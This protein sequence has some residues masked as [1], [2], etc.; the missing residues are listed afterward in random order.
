MRAFWG[1]PDKGDTRSASGM[2]DASAPGM[3][4]PA[5][6]AG[7]GTCAPWATDRFAQ[8]GGAAGSGTGAVEAGGA[9]VPTTPHGEGNKSTNGKETG[10]PRLEIAGWHTWSRTP[11]ADGGDAS[12]LRAPSTANYLA[13]DRTAG[14]AAAR[15]GEGAGE[16]STPPSGIPAGGSGMCAPWATALHI[17]VEISG[18]GMADPG[19]EGGS[20]PL[21]ATP[22]SWILAGEGGGS[23]SRMH[24]ALV[25]DL[26]AVIPAAGE[27]S[28]AR[29]PSTADSPV[30]GHGPGI[31]TPD[32][33]STAR[34]PPTTH[35]LAQDH[36]PEIPAPVEG[37]GMRA[38]S[39]TDS[40]VR[41]NG[42]RIAAPGEGSE[43]RASW[44]TV[45]RT[46]AQARG[47]GTTDVSSGALAPW[48]Q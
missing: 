26:G 38:P 42:A 5:F 15:A 16:R 36:D 14:M 30:Q 33:V 11:A 32:N 6:D 9:R 3:V 31:A 39:V 44:A 17:P 4:A 13:E 34:A 21:A 29:P 24:N 2:R 12:G 25:K 43:M 27:G 28:G 47:S 45:P 22:A 23:V 46:P 19:E 48:T 35:S 20:A 37:G 41:D 7:S 10:E 40:L 8:G 1:A 18:S